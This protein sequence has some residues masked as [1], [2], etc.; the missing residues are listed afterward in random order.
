MSLKQCAEYLGVSD[1][2]VRRWEDGSR[3]IK[4]AIAKL[5]VALNTTNT[6]ERG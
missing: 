2:S 1:R 3:P 4:V 6:Q 5:M